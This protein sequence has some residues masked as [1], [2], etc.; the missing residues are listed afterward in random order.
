MDTLFGG[1]LRTD[2]LVAIARLGETYPAQ[3]AALFDR[4]HSQVQR[5]VASLESARVIVSTPL[6]SVRRLRLNPEF[7]GFP[8]LQALLLE[9]ALSPRYEGMWQTIG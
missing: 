9:M 2:T 7:P 3:L 4:H 6:G 1:S 5:T 8:A